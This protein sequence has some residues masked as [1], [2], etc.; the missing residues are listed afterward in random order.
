[1]FGKLADLLP[2]FLQELGFPDK[3]AL[4]LLKGGGAQDEPPGLD[5]FEFLEDFFQVP[6]GF[7]SSELRALPGNACPWVGP[8]GRRAARVPPPTLAAPD[9]SSGP[10]AGTLLADRGIA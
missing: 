4:A 6:G 8:G 2:D 9:P 1:L 7:R 10:G 5:K 3:L